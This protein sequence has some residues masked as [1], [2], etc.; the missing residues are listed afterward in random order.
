[1]RGVAT[2]LEVIYGATSLIPFELIIVCSQ[3]HISRGEGHELRITGL[4]TA[5][6]LANCSTARVSTRYKSVNGEHDNSAD[7]RKDQAH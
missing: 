2:E 7:D 5:R 3:T 1:M 4:R 6:P